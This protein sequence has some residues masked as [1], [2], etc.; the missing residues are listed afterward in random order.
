MI[1]E[2]IAHYRIVGKLGAGGMG[3]VYRALDENLGRD[4][5]IKVLHREMMRDPD[6]LS[7]FELEAKAVAKLA[8]PNIL[9]IHDFGRDG[10]VAYT[11]TELLEGETLGSG[12]CANACTGPRR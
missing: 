9:A 8:H 7:L 2:S 3:V 11:V 12:S 5:A 4:V 6:R 1:G 10:D